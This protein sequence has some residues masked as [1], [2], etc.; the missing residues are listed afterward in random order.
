GHGRAGDPGPP[1]R[2]STRSPRT[3]PTA[4]NGDG[5]VAQTTSSTNPNISPAS[6]TLGGRIRCGQ[7]VGRP[8]EPRP[9]HHQDPDGTSGSSTPPRSTAQTTPKQTSTPG[10]LQSRSRR[11]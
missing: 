8:P 9:D 11:G 3:G 7:R 1:R 10:P 6:K 2:R 4:V 5:V